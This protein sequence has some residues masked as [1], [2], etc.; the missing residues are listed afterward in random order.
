MKKVFLFLFVLAIIVVERAPV[1]YSGES[2]SMIRLMANPE[3]YYEKEV[4][5][6]G[7][8]YFNEVFPTEEYTKLLAIPESGVEIHDPSSDGS[9]VSSCD[10]RYVIVTG[11]VRGEG[12]NYFYLD[13]ISSVYDIQAKKYCW[14]K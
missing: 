14:R 6:A 12:P 10:E 4:K 9:M 7:W 11:V 8:L 1:A 5:F 3:R 13:N 2:I